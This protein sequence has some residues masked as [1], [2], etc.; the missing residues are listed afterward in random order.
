[1]ICAGTWRGGRDGE[2]RASRT[3]DSIA[4]AGA[5]GESEGLHQEKNR[6]GPHAPDGRTTSLADGGGGHKMEHG[7]ADHGGKLGPWAAQRARRTIAEA[8]LEALATAV[9][10]HRETVGEEGR[11]ARPDD[12]VNSHVL[13]AA[14]AVATQ[15]DRLAGAVELIEARLADDATRPL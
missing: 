5:E 15:L 4:P 8:A 13:I 6:S 9:E 10:V 1:M 7:D 2:C 3:E 14:L 11:I 12:E